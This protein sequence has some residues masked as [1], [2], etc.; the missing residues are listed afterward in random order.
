MGWGFRLSRYWFFLLFFLSCQKW[1]QHLSKIFELQSSC[2]LLLHSSCHLGS[3]PKIFALQVGESYSNAPVLG[4]S[5]LCLF[6]VPPTCHSK[7]LHNLKV[8]LL[9]V[10]G[11]H[12]NIRSGELVQN[13]LY[14]TMELLKW[15]PLSIIVC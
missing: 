8:R 7:K 4:N 12:E 1:L 11:R 5:R 6:L 10:E 3:S 15:N 9:N 13:E 2:C 14:A